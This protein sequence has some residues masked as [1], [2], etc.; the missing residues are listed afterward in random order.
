MT[1][2]FNR[3]DRNIRLL[4][5]FCLKILYFALYCLFNVDFFLNSKIDA[6]YLCVGMK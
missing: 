2:D 6:F 5:H 3:H 4:V 1:R